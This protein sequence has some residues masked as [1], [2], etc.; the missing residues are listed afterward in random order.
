M[1]VTLVNGKR[2][3]LRRPDEITKINYNREALFVFKGGEMV[4]G[5][6]DGK[7]S[8]SLFHIE[9]TVHCGS[10]QTERLIGWCYL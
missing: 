9:D 10:Y 7:V 1:T 8:G 4:Y 3:T 6:C 5:Y 2:R